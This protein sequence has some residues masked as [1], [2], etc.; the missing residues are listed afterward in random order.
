MDSS[1]VSNSYFGPNGIA[2]FNTAINENTTVVG[3]LTTSV[4]TYET[5]SMYSYSLVAGTGSEDNA[6]FSLSGGVLSFKTAPNFE[7][8]TDIGD[9]SG[10]N[11]YSVRIR[12]QDTVDSRK[13]YEE[14]FVITVK[15]ANE[16]PTVGNANFSVF[17]LSPNG[18][19]VGTNT[20][21]DVDVGDML[22][23]SFLSGNTGSVFAV[24]ASGKITIA[25]N[26]ALKNFSTFSLVEQV[27]DA[28]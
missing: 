10:N 14:S 13:F 1:V 28:E 19:L 5:G 4:P 27:T 12:T 16:A 20:G 25:D 23:Y 21:S 11:T 6:K 24:D 3:N 18:T 8:P 26:S 9:S 22:S 7:N 2:L 15:N 17:D